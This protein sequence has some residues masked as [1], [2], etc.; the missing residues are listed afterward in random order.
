MKKLFQLFMVAAV[1]LFF[2]GCASKPVSVLSF[3]SRSPWARARGAEATGSRRRLAE[4]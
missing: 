4:G 3:G 2:Q 1:I